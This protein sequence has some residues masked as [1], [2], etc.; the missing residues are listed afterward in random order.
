MRCAASSLPT[1]SSLSWLHMLTP[2]LLRLIGPALVVLGIA[3]VVVI[4]ARRT[5][6]RRLREL[7]AWWGHIPPDQSTLAVARVLLDHGLRGSQENTYS[8]DNTT[9]ADLD[10]DELF[11]RLNRCVSPLGSQVLY[12]MMRQPRLDRVQ[13]DRRSEHTSRFCRDASL[14]EQL[15]LTLFAL[16]DRRVAQLARMLWD[17]LPQPLPIAYLAPFLSI[18]AIAGFVLAWVGL[19]S[20]A[21]L[22]AFFLLNSI[23]HFVQR[24][25]LEHLPLRQLGALLSAAHQMAQHVH[26]LPSDMA[27]H[28]R[29]AVAATKAL[30]RRLAPLEIEDD[31]GLVQY[32]KIYL[33]LDVI[34]YLLVA[35]LVRSKS[36]ELRTL[37][38]VLGEIDA[39]LAVASYLAENSDVCRPELTPDAARWRLEGIRHPL[40]AAPVRNDFQLAH[41]AALITGS[42]MSGKTTFLKTLGVNA[43]LAQTFDFALATAYTMPFCRVL[44][45]ISRA[46]SLV[47]GRSYYLAE[48]ESI[49]RLVRVAEARDLHLLLADEIFRGTNPEERVAGAAA[50]LGWLAQGDHIVLA[51]THDLELVN[52]LVP[53]YTSYHFAESIDARGLSFDFVIRPGPSTTRNALNLM[54][55][56]GYPAMLVQQARTLVEARTKRGSEPATTTAT[57]GE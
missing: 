19:L 41:R 45:S 31:L 46:D 10:L 37:F 32:V 29:P 48:V 49:L 2:E 15:Q 24:R 25:D 9:W 54:E 51:A 20:W 39:L 57:P 43:V 14:R 38:A 21:A 17:D 12:V 4:S 16:R 7:R 55:R 22:V 40:I 53:T 26:A 1:R 11:G 27:A 18:A 3:A 42:N 34:A 47:E 56:A 8:L 44:T 13:L 36:A 50:V 52:L 28:I 23:V 6:A 5:K 33:L 30:R 35:P